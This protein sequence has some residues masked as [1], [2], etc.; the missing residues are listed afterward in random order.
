MGEAKAKRAVLEEAQALFDVFH[1]SI[2][3][4]TAPGAV[5]LACTRLLADL[6]LEQRGAD[7]L[8]TIQTIGAQI[9]AFVNE[10]VPT[11]P[12]SVN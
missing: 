2:D 1:A 10:P 4:D 6:I 3:E 8:R 7:R 11:Q 12:G 9:V 5:V